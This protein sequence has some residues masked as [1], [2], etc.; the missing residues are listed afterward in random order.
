MPNQWQP[1][2]PVK[3]CILE[4]GLVGQQKPKCKDNHK[5]FPDFEPEKEKF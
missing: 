2:H 4:I 3:N 5:I 1:Y